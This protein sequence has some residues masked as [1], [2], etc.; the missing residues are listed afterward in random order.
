MNNELHILFEDGHLFV[1]NKP[2]GVDM[3]ALTIRYPDLLLVHRLDKETS[4]VLMFAKAE[5]AQAR[6]K[7]QFAR[8][9]IKKTYRVFVYGALP[10]RGVIDKPIGSAR[11]G[12]GPRSA[13]HPYGTLREATTVYRSIAHGS[14]ATYAEVFPKTGRTHQ[15]RVHFAAVGHPVV[16]DKQYAAGREGLLG[17]KRQALHA[18]SLVIVH[19]ERG[20]ETEFKAPL[21]PDFVAAEQE[22]RAG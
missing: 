14:S 8:R 21:P 19:P 2:A 10:E 4:G 3:E 22:L 15:I 7:K 9:E 20:V 18:L 1:I 5:L 11:G 6:I 16:A 12:L 17:F 13:K